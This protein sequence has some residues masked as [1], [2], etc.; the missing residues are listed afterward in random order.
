M[1]NSWIV[2]L[3]VVG[4]SAISVSAQTIVAE[5]EYEGRVTPATERSSARTATRWTLYRKS[6]KSYTLKSEIV[7]PPDAQG[8]IFQVEELD[9]TLAPSAIGYEAYEKGQVKPIATSSCKFTQGAIDC[10]MHTPEGD[11]GCNRHQEERPFW[12]WIEDMFSLDLP[13]SFGGVVNMAHL[14]KGKTPMFVLTLGG[15]SKDAPC[16]LTSEQEGSIEF[17]G[18]ESIDFP[19]AKVTVKRYRFLDGPT[20]KNSEP[21]DVTIAGP[22]IVVKISG[23]EGLEFILTNYKQYEKLIPELPVEIRPGRSVRENQK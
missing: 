3:L 19:G 16:D 7:G 22:G 20:Q 8:K 21:I 1:R 5:G 12:F 4:L 6:P 17:V 13:W 9:E 23:T 2:V 11:A 14:E 18:I 10:R 15:G